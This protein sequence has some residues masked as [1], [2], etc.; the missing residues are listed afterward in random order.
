[1][2]RMLPR[3]AEVVPVE[4]DA[5][6]GPAAFVR[7]VRWSERLAEGT[8]KAV[9]LVSI[10]SVLLILAFIGKE[11]LPVLTSADVHREVTPGALFLPHATA[12]FLWQPVSDDPKYNILPLVAGTLKSNTQLNQ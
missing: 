1:M 5:A 2:P 11:A 10:L 9:A 6:R 8:V 3:Q 4:A 12:G 7:H